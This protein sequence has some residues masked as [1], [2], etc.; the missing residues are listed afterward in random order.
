MIQGVVPGPTP[1]APSAPPAAPQLSG[2]GIV[3]TNADV[4]HALNTLGYSPALVVDGIIGPKSQAGVKGFQGNNGLTVDGIPGPKT[5]AALV[6][7]LAGSPIPASSLAQPAAVVPAVYTPPAPTAPLMAPAPPMAVNTNTD[8]QRAIN[9]LGYSPPLT[10]DGAIGP[11]S[12]AAVKWFSK[13]TGS[14]STAC[15]VP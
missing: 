3:A 1:A 5:K 11:K 4:Q 6:A 8:V 9:A 7:A 10:V 14:P 2:P 12:I 15:P 13:T